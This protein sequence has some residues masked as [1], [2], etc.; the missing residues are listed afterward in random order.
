MTVSNPSL[1]S[2]GFIAW[3][4]ALR[5]LAADRDLAWLAETP[6]A[7]HHAAFT[8]GLSPAEY[9]DTYGAMAQWRGCGCG[10]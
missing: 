4:A 10:G 3:I 7:S 2:P 6:G 5:A 1:S 9:L 8:A